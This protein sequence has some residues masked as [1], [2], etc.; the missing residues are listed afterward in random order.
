MI[1]AYEARLHM[2]GIVWE[3]E[4]HQLENYISKKIRECAHAGL[5]SACVAF[6]P[7]FAAR[8][9]E[10]VERSLRD[11]GYR[12]YRVANYFYIRWN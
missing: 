8:T 2:K 9:I 11:N 6:H 4:H 7:G 1:S 5:S 10:K 12:F 3:E